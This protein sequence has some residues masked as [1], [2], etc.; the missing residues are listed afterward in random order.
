MKIIIEGP[1]GSGK[2]T[3][4]GGLIKAAVDAGE[5][6]DIEHHGRYKGLPSG[7]LYDQ[8]R[9]SLM[10]SHWMNRSWIS[11]MV[12]SPCVRNERPRLTG[13]QIE[14]L[15]RLAEEQGYVIIFCL[16]SRDTVVDNWS[17]KNRVEYIEEAKILHEVYDMYY[18]LMDN[19]GSWTKL[20]LIHY[21]Y[22]DEGADNIAA[23]RARIIQA[24]PCKRCG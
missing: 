9:D 10:N 13:L 2:S 15:D 8:Y 18:T 4:M 21:N 14:H 7:V 20:P 24:T 23:L 22:E 6:I 3:L 5:T 11:E 12:Y 19:S 16:P 1:D 17:D